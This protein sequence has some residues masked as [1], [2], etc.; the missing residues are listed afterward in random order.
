MYEGFTPGLG[1]L[2]YEGYQVQERLVMAVKYILV[3]F[4]VVID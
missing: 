3:Y 2:L 1:I 4:K